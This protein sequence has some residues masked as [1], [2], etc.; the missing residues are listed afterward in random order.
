MGIVEEWQTTYTIAKL[1][2][3]NSFIASGL[4]VG[5]EELASQQE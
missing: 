1:S 4:V 2:T 3:G 5:T